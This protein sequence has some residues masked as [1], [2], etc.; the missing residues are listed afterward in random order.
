M[1]QTPEDQAERFPRGAYPAM[2]TPF[3]ETKAIDWDGVDRATDFYVRS[4]VT[5][6]FVGGLSA[7]IKWMSDDE[8]VALAER[9]VRRAA[10][11]V[12]VVAGAI[13]EGSLDEQAD[14]VR[15][16]H[17]TGADAV[18]IAVCQFADETEDDQVWIQRAETFLGHVPEE[19][20]LAFYECPLP[21]WRLLS[22]E[23]IEWAA[24]GGRFHFLKDTCC[25]IER[26]R[27]RLEII[28]DTRLQLFN[29]NAETF[30][31]SLQAGAEGFCG[32]GANYFPELYVW[33]CRHFETDPELAA[34]LHGFMNETFGLTE[35]EFYP[36]TAKE[37]LRLEGLDIGPFSRK[38]P[39]DLP[40]QLL[41]DLEDMRLA[42]NRWTKRL[43]G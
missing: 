5:G 36:V 27:A 18:S 26:I 39:P 28:R 43:R 38:L 24:R 12:K 10:G 41:K 30:L 35:G 9:I 23:T 42:A 15:R 29:A 8:K 33:L 11:R 22:Q 14:L 17:A 21:Y 31:A 6:I 20:R 40:P 4:R 25:N 2:V 32:I 19:I 37:Y 1:T 7:E 16:V 13:S 34:N 3:D